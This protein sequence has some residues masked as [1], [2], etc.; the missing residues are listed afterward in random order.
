MFEDLNIDATVNAMK[1][2]YALG[3]IVHALVAATSVLLLQGIK[4]VCILPSKC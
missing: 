2:E 4:M 1:G 3:F